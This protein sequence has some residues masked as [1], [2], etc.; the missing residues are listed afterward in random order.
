M[1]K[2][3]KLGAAGNGRLRAAENLRNR[4][5]YLNRLEGMGLTEQ[6]HETA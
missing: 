3:G 2:N 5:A 6:T 4:K 1:K